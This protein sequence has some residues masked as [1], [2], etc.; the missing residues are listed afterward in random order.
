MAAS[1]ATGPSGAKGG[2]A[3]QAATAAVRSPKGP[4]VVAQRE[5]VVESR[6][7]AKLSASTLAQ[8]VHPQRCMT[9]GRWGTSALEGF[10]SFMAET[11]MKNSAKGRLGDDVKIGAVRKKCGQKGLLIECTAS[12]LAC[13]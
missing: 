4:D 10:A 8:V 13:R 12:T 3:T 5:T 11:A 6:E 7:L 1:E 9:A 2:P